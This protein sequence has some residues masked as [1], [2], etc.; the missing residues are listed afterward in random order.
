MQFTKPILLLI[1]NRPDTTAS[2]F[3]RIKE[4]K[5]AKLFVAADGPRHKRNGEAEL[6]QQAREIVLSQIDWDCEVTTLFREENLGCGKAVSEAISWFFEQVEEGIILEDDTL[7]DVSF[8]YFAAELLERYRNNP[9]VTSI[10]AANLM[11]D[12]MPA[13]ANSYTFSNYG[14]IWGW[15]SWRRAWQGYDYSIASWNRLSTRLQFLY[16]YGI[17]QTLFFHSLFRK[18]TVEKNLNTWDYQWW[19]HQLQQ[20]GLAV[21]PQQNL[22]KNIGFGSAATHTSNEINLELIVP[23]AEISFPLKHPEK[24]ATEKHFER[25]ISKKFYSLRFTNLQKLKLLRQ[26][27]LKK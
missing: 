26:L 14:G 6:C 12:K 8:F 17:G 7:V 1:F 18:V 16:R 22:M 13:L 15:A 9:S 11:A 21:I 5:P 20:S 10:T 19:Y 3:A 4:V 24:A 23:V 27:L 25:S 2:V